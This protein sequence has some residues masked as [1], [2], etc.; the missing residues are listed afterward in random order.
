MHKMF[1]MV[2]DDGKD[3]FK[4]TR[5][6]ESQ[7]DIE[8]RYGGNGEFVRIKDVTDDYPISEYKLH[9]AL[10]A[11]GFGEAERESIVSLLRQEYSN[12]MA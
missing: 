4:V 5:M 9:T 7:E 10:S 8:K 1:E 12:T 11:A 2:I 6:A 3:V